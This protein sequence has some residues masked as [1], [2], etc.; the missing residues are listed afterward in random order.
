MIIWDCAAANSSELAVPMSPNSLFCDSCRHLQTS[1]DGCIYTMETA[2]V[3]NSGLVVFFF[4]GVV[5][6]GGN[7]VVKHLLHHNVFPK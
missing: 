2:N 3:Y 5:S 7:P 4:G 6:M 1:H